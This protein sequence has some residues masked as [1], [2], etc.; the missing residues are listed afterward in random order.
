MLSY[1]TNSKFDEHTKDKFK[2]KHDSR[3]FRLLETVPYI[4][5][6]THTKIIIRITYC[7]FYALLIHEYTYTKLLNQ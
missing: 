7:S 4:V 3:I 1:E 6:I 2:Y 5:S